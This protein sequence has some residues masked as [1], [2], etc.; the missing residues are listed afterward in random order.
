MRPLIWF[1]LLFL[2][3]L[4][5]AQT[6][7]DVA[8]S[9]DRRE[10]T[11]IRAAADKLI[12]SGSPD[13][14]IKGAA[15]LEKAA[16]LEQQASNAERQAMEIEKLK[17]DLDESQRGHW[18]DALVSLIP[19][20]ST[21]ILAGTLIFQISQARVERKEKREEQAAEARQKE[22]QR[23]MDAL[24]EIQ[25]S[26]KIST[27]A[28]IIN[29]FQEEPYRSQVLD[30]AVKL[31]LMRESME[32]FQ[33]LFMAVMN[34]LTYDQLPQM[35][36][37]CKEVDK[38]YFTI[39]TPIW[40]DDTSSTDVTK[41][42]N[43]DRKS[44]EL[45]SQEQLFLSNKLSGLLR[46][47]PPAGMTVDLSQL[48]LREMDLSGVDLGTANIAATNWTYVNLD[49][50]DMSRV[51]E[52]DNCLLRST[53]W[54]HAARVS[55]PLLN[56]LSKSCAYSAKQQYN[57]KLPVGPEEYAACVAKLE[58]GGSDVGGSRAWGSNSPANGG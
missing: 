27:A 26:E 8:G 12:A 4:A 23:F 2:S 16:E 24:K 21:V 29:T 15:L 7:G 58:A 10:A 40:N 9:T 50:C 43:A 53:A 11:E 31:L 5:W 1:A 34:P 46:T 44:F 17:R 47:T 52:F 41:L 20:A 55:K 28:A 33:T 18:R 51:M 38:S 19:L 14:V 39:A 37:L 30:M 6:A 56:W 25:T 36:R 54:W 32:E 35:Q 45:Y 42:N 57:T 48:N 13:D 49:G 22:Q 3:A